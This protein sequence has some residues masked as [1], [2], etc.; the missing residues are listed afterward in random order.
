MELAWLSSHGPAILVSTD[1]SSTQEHSPGWLG[2][3]QKPISESPPRS[4]SSPNDEFY[5][6]CPV[7]H[8]AMR[9]SCCASVVN[10][11]SALSVLNCG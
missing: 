3:R 11:L 5:M 6:T 9:S 1:P 7:F 8:S 10:H 2:T 4:T